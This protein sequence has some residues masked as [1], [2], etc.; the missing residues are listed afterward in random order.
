MISPPKLENLGK[1]ISPL[2]ATYKNLEKK[3]LIKKVSRFNSCY[4]PDFI[5]RI[6]IQSGIG[7]SFEEPDP[8][9]DSKFHSCVE[10]ELEQFQFSFKDWEPAEVH[11][12]SQEPPNTGIEQC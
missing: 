7:N 6:Q 8:K 3:I 4:S 10:P 5:F 9:L 1:F 11:H 2:G 12:K